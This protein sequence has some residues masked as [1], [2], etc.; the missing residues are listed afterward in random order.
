MLLMVGD[1]MRCQNRFVIRR[2][3]RPYPCDLWP[4]CWNQD[5]VCVRIRANPPLNT[6]LRLLNAVLQ[7][8]DFQARRKLCLRSFRSDCLSI[9]QH[10]DVI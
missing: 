10:V 3:S 6:L 9:T 5:L 7:L 1:P 2:R 4:V 8:A